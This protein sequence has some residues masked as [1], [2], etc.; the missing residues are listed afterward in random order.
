MAG[1]F[2]SLLAL[3]FLVSSAAGAQVDACALNNYT[4]W[5]HW[6][7]PPGQEPT[8]LSL[9]L[10]V[11]AGSAPALGERLSAIIAPVQHERPALHLFVSDERDRLTVLEQLRAFNDSSLD[12]LCVGS[13]D[14]FS[15]R[16][17]DACGHDVVATVSKHMAET[18]PTD[19]WVLVAP[20]EASPKAIQMG[21]FNL[22]S[23]PMRGRGASTEVKLL[24]EKHFVNAL[25][26][27]ALNAI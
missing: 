12:S 24:D 27:T 16:N 10:V 3:Y 14:W 7:S 25:L 26:P 11:R 20:L 21:W 15:D 4:E 9:V 5:A 18:T 17:L 1:V 8:R 19:Q 2:V 13:A 6:P 22:L 23:E